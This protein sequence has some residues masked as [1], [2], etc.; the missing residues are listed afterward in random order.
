MILKS[1]NKNKINSRNATGQNISSR[2]FLYHRIFV[3]H[4]LSALVDHQANQPHNPP[5][6]CPQCTALLSK[7]HIYPAVRWLHQCLG[8]SWGERSEV[9]GTGRG[10]RARAAASHTG[11]SLHLCISAAVVI[12]HSVKRRRLPNTTCSAFTLPCL[13]L[14]LCFR[15]RCLH[16][17]IEILVINF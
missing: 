10:G 4:A 13:C 17:E 2:N 15:T 14:C 5:A 11:P 1:I 8:V 12:A 6:E 7:Y 3:Y 9:R 16:I